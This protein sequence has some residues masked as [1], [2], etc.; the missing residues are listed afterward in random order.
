MAAS[1]AILCYYFCFNQEGT[2]WIAGPDKDSFLKTTQ[3]THWSKLNGI[4]V[5]KIED[6]SPKVAGIMLDG[7]FDALPIKGVNEAAI[8]YEAPMEG[9][10]TRFLAIYPAGQNIAEV[11]PVRSARPYFLDWL[12]EYGDALY[13]H[14]GGS[15]EAL[16]LIQ[17]RKIFDANEFYWGGYYW[18]DHS[19]TAPYN[20]FTASRQWNSIFEKYGEVFFRDMESKIVSEYSVKSDSVIATGGGTLIFDNNYSRV[21][22]NGIIFC[23]KAE[24]TIVIKRLENSFARPLL[25]GQILSDRINTLLKER[26]ELYEK[27]PNQIDTSFLSASEVAS[28]IIEI[29]NQKISH[30]DKK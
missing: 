15:P 19:R 10:T 7:H 28:R 3:F 29:Y 21:S 22:E 2:T 24:K 17:E 6:E 16:D 5:E 12:A 25:S 23:L 1:A 11:G 26:K 8:I 18:R 27:L 4:G 9:V 13:M 20:L 14:C 30:V